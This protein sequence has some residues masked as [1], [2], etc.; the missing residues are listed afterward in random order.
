MQVEVV[1]PSGAGTGGVPAIITAGGVT[2]QAEGA[3]FLK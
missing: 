3:V 1:V 2:S